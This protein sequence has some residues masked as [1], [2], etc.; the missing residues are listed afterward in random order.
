MCES[1]PKNSYFRQ[2]RVITSAEISYYLSDIY[3]NRGKP[4]YPNRGLAVLG[5]GC[6]GVLD[7]K[8]QDV[9][10]AASAL[11][12]ILPRPLDQNL[13]PADALSR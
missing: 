1:T 8:V 9:F 5:E 2:L 7:R 6:R 13:S 11:P 10:F 12:R 3:T 4:Y